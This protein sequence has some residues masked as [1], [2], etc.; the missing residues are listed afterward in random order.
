MIKPRTLQQ[1][2]SAYIQTAAPMAGVSFRGSDSVAEITL[3]MFIV[4]VSSIDEEWE[5]T[6]IYRCHVVLQ[7]HTQAEDEDGETAASRI[8]PAMAAMENEDAV[9]AALEEHFSMSAL[10]FKGFNLTRKDMQLI[11]AARYDLLL[12]PHVEIPD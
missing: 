8:E 7:L 11:H 6:G 4:H 10:M 3:P 9:A 12:A 2:L 1:D 5:D